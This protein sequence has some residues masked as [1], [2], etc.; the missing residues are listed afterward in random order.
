MLHA[1]FVSS[2]RATCASHLILL[3]LITPTALG[4]GTN[5]E[6]PYVAVFRISLLLSVI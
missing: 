1:V 2:I 5:Y 3:G 4:D 6:T